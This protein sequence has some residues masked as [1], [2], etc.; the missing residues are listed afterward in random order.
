[1]NG[2]GIWHLTESTSD[3]AGLVCFWLGS[4]SAE[5]VGWFCESM[6]A[7]GCTVTTR[8]KFKRTEWGGRCNASCAAEART[9]LQHRGFIIRE[10]T[11]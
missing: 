1:M 4:C 5:F 9:E 8:Q 11:P 3:T 10:V 6:A 2:D 7:A